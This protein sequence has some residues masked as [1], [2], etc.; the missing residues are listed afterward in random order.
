MEQ[1]PLPSGIGQAQ[2]KLREI[3]S[4]V[5]STGARTLENAS[6]SQGTLRVK[7]GG[8]IVI[9]DGGTLRIESG[10]LILGRGKIRGDALAEQFTAKTYSIP[11]EG[12]AD[13]P[14]N[15]WRFMRQVIISPP[16]WAQR[17][18][19]IASWYAYQIRLLN[20]SDFYY[21]AQA[22]LAAGSK[23]LNP[24]LL[25]WEYT[26]ETGT[27]GRTRY[28]ASGFGILEIPGNQEFPLGVQGWATTAKASMPVQMDATCLFTRNN[29]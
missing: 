7:H 15:S 6:I 13:S 23:E 5:D 29:S 22:R 28:S 11:L 19:I 27:N 10:D 17:T 14:N 16:S 24:R 21:R 2:R 4:A 1:V 25:Q 26:L 18:L 9:S 3:Q 20:D 8:N 12:A